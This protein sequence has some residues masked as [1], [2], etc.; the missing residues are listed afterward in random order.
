MFWHFYKYR[1]KVLLRNK[2]MLF[3][4]LA[5]PILLG[6]MFMAA[7]GEIDQAGNLETITTGIVKTGDQTALTE[8]F[9]TVL[10]Q[11][12]INEKPLFALEELQ[13]TEAVE[14][15][16]AGELAGYFLIDDKTISLHVGQAGMSQTLMKNVMD[17]FLQRTAIISSK[18]AELET[19]DLAPIMAAFEQEAAFQEVNADRDMSVKSFYFFTLIG[20]AIL[21]GTMWGVRN[22]QDQQANQSAN[23]IRLSLIPRKR[24]LVSSANLAASFTIVLV[25]VYIIL[26]V[27]RFVYQVDFGDRWQWLLLVAALGSLC[28]ILLGT[29]IGNLTPKMNLVQKDGILVSVTMAMSF[30]A[31]MMGSEQIKYWLDLHVPILGQVNPVNLISESLYQLYYYTDLS[32][33]YTNLF[34]LTG[35]IVLLSIGNAWI[36]RG[37]RYDAL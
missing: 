11:V 15:L 16:T 19:L 1:T 36:E 26:A 6:L 3:W 25:E 4:T 8:N 13:E 17:Q 7:F 33:F 30:F 21:Y 12:E 28:A 22:V 37:V 23:G 18:A 27:F 20:M 31:G 29:L 5:F 2:S 24:T 32:S 9:S 34:W 35:F 10:E 14:K